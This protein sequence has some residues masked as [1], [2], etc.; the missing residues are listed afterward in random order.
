MA[1]MGKT[2]LDINGLGLLSDIENITSTSFAIEIARPINLN[3]NDNFHIGISQPLR[4]ESGNASIAIPQLYDINGN[5]N[6]DEVSF[7]LAPSGRQ[8][9]F[10]IGYSAKLEDNL[11][12]G[13][14][15]ALSKDY[16]HI[17]SQNLTYS[18]IGFLKFDF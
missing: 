11:N 15:M 5:L 16:G 4:I 3:K 17:Q 12:L 7:E 9:D 2:E 18:T 14:L 1:T 10:N 13:L 8:I 6:Y